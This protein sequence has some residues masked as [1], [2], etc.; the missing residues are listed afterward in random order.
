MFQILYM[1]SNCSLVDPQ[2]RTSKESL[3]GEVSFFL[4]CVLAVG[5]VLG[6]GYSKNKQVSFWILSFFL[7]M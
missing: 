3:E 4:G 1:T 6:A 2:V 7:L 5:T